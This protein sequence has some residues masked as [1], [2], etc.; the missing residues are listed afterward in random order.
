MRK[1]LLLFKLWFDRL[2][3]K[4]LLQQL[5]VLVVILCLAYL[6]S[7][8]MLACSRE[9]WLAFCHDKSVK[10]GNP[11]LWP[12]YLL[13]DTNA[14]NNM[15]VGNHGSGWL[16]FVSTTIFLFGAFIFNGWIIGLIS[17]A[18][19][20]RIKKHNDGF[21]HYLTS[22]HYIIMGADIMLPSIIRQILDHD[23]RAY[24]LL[25]TAADANKIRE[26]L[27]AYFSSQQLERLIINYGHRMSEEYY[28]DIHIEGAKEIFIVGMRSTEAHDAI[29][30]E[31][32]DAIRRYLA[33]R[34]DNLHPQRITCVF[35]DLDTY[36][37]FKTSEIFH[38]VPKLGIEF[39]PYNYYAFWARQIFVHQRHA[40][41]DGRES[42]NIPYPPVF[43]TG[44]LP[45]QHRGITPEDKHFVHLVFVGTTNFAVAFAMEAA[46]ILHF[47]NFM[48]NGRPHRTRITF[49]DRNA[50]TE[51]DIFI[52]R[53]R[54]L[55]D[56]QP[57]IYQ[58][59]TDEAALRKNTNPMGW[60]RETLNPKYKMHDFLD[61]EF[62]FIRGD[63]FSHRVQQQI[64]AWAEDAD[65]QYLSIFLAQ[66]SQ[67]LNFAMGMNMPDEVYDNNIPIFIRQ[68]RSDNF[69]TDL[70]YVA[71]HPY[72]TPPKYHFVDVNGVCQEQ[73][74]KGRYANIYPFGMSDVSFSFDT[75]SLL[76]AK[77]IN[78][79]YE[80]AKYPDNKFKSI[81]E[82][83][84]TPNAKLLQDAT[85]RWDK[86]SVALKWS[87]MYCAFSI[88]TKL[89]TLRA[90]RG[91][92][93]TDTSHD[94][95]PL[96]EDEVCAM[97]P[98]EHNRWN[99]EK[100]LMGFRKAYPNEDMYEYSTNETTA[101]KLK[102]NRKHLIHHDIRPFSDLK[103]IRQLDYE[104]SRYIP[105][106]VRKS[107]S[108]INT[109]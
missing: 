58:D 25:I 50:D 90:M 80:T 6:L 4:T 96:S 68:D 91:L 24:I 31:C 3:S 54:H 47:P 59:L 29:N 20:R 19:E 27:L 18:I 92:T 94:T 107:G 56:I 42:C 52:T 79:L 86:L 101:S 75:E 28:D 87:N 40:D 9:S 78:Y 34:N 30:V 109:N 98:V 10:I 70:R 1:H 99:V 36:A 65:G 85:E 71:Y 23:E 5:V 38:E 37:A 74:R 53:N 88:P 35:E 12:L 57:Y 8:G 61:V 11:L 55:F 21:I 17:N 62:E 45:E 14:L 67:R 60:G 2:L 39:V 33:K 63:V 15:Y 7:V 84:A 49:I 100:L 48:H 43:G 26:N 104:L 16:L 76:R 66:P 46:H 13:L 103:E 32:V 93:P 41:A 51:K 97:A 108:M 105:W 72:K 83:D 64:R 81:I 44:L 82:L 102:D 95:D 89:A 73:E 69:V 106:I 22:G 77:L